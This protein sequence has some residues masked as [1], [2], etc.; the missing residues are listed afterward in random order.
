LKSDVIGSGVGLSYHPRLYNFRPVIS[1]TL[2]IY[3]AASN[4]GY[5]IASNH[6]EN[7]NTIDWGY[8]TG[9]SGGISLNLSNRF[10]LIPFIGYRFSDT[11]KV[12]NNNSGNI[13]YKIDYTSL[14]TGLYLS[15][16]L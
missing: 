9:L 14:W 7:F 10:Y 15:Y 2:M 12:Y 16:N 11:I 4:A 1:L 6:V 13:V 8:W 3:R 5:R